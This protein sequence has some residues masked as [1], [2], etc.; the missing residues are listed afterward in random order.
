MLTT[1]KPETYAIYGRISMDKDND[2][3]G[4]KRQVGLGHQLAEQRGYVRAEVPGSPGW[5]RGELVDN[6]ISASKGKRRD[7]YERLLNYVLAEKIDVIV[8]YMSS[9]LWRNR[10]ERAIAFER[11][12]QSKVKIV[13]VRGQEIDLSTAAGRMIAGILGEVDA[14]ETEQMGERKRDAMAQ[15]A[16]LGH[17]IG[18]TPFGYR[19][20]YASVPLPDGSTGRRYTGGLEVVPDLRDEIR[21]AA[22]HL[23]NGGSLRGVALDWNFRGIRTARGGRWSLQQLRQILLAPYMV[24]LRGGG[25]GG[26]GRSAVYQRW[27]P[28]D[29]GTYKGGWEAVLD[30]ET[31]EALHSLL[32]SPERVT[33]PGGSGRAAKHLLSGIARC[34]H[35]G[36]SV[37]ANKYNNRQGGKRLYYVCPDPPTGCGKSARKAEVVDA[38]VLA[39]IAHW[40]VP[41]GAYDAALATAALAATP[42]M[43]VVFA[44]Q[45]RDRLAREKLDDRLAD[46]EFDDD[47]GR[48]DLDSY[49]RQCRRLDQRMADRKRQIDQLGLASA[50]DAMP[51]RGAGFLATWKALSATPQGVQKQREIVRAMV[52]EIVF[53]PTTR[54]NKVDLSKIRVKPSALLIDAPAHLLAVPAA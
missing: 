28:T 3:A 17:Y 9:R 1:L 47:D 49:R 50:L 33:R 51:E 26:N 8:L 46:G 24:G 13:A 36:K 34:G 38:W 10:K 21:G 44:E 2:Q 20:V 27:S 19:K 11:L 39:H 5:G 41:N 52:E 43:A 35:C 37:Y 23:L 25:P 15:Q 40:L 22:E 29:A 31:R 14:H 45:S 53:E 30:L 12:A 16:R 48:T 42:E 6:D 7:S 32:T 18:P 54:S 4:V